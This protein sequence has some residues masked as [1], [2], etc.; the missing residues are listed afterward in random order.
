MGKEETV[1]RVKSISVTL[2]TTSG[3]RPCS[4]SPRAV[5][6]GSD[7]DRKIAE[8]YRLKFRMPDEAALRLFKCGSVRA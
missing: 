2:I 7:T 1:N 8:S 6:S 3:L 4:Q 5:P